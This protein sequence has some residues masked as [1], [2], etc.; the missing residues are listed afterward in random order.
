MPKRN[1]I[2]VVTLL[3]VAGLLLLLARRDPPPPPQ[4]P[5]PLHEVY[6]FIKKNFYRELSD[7]ELR[8]ADIKGLAA[9]MAAIDPWST[10]IRPGQ[11]G[12]IERRLQGWESG[13]GLRLERVGGQVFIIGPV[14]G[15]PGDEAD[16]YSGDR[17]MEV[18]GKPVDAL[19]LDK[20]YRLLAGKDGSTVTLKIFGVDG[21][22]KKIELTRRRFQVETL[23][24]LYRGAGR[25]WVYL[26]E[27]AEG[28][29]YVRL[30]EFV[31]DSAARLQQCLRGLDRYRALVVD[32]RDNPGGPLD[33][34]VSVSNLF[35]DK[36]DIVSVVRRGKTVGKYSA[37]PD[38]TCASEIR[39]VV[40]VNG[41]TA[42]AAE[43]VAGALGMYDRAVL[44]GTRTHG[45]GS[46]QK[47]LDLPDGMGQINL[48]VAEYRLGGTEIISRRAGS[49]KWGVDPHRQVVIHSTQVE[50]LRRLRY[51]AEVRRGRPTTSY[52]AVDAPGGLAQRL[53]TL[54]LQLAQAV[55][56][57]KAP[58]EYESILKEAAAARAEQKRRLLTDPS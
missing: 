13:L 47:L 19:A 17:V 11:A 5:A 18:N 14:R 24:G 55:D 29:A 48:T 10:I 30:R 25:Q 57:L 36:G 43:I 6:E 38:G 31:S 21:G 27:K 49:G 51:E 58:G 20:V 54:D 9:S 4:N 8:E 44:V 22:Q 34:A 23:T 37:T 1:I 41:H 45:K 39:L 46:V 56:I 15:S 33:S 12:R 26:V 52:P 40:L 7:E 35:L 2:L 53:M 42:S 28:I 50:E 3:C 16:I 32:L